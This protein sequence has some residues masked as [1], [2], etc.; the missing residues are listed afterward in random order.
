MT[1]YKLAFFGDFEKFACISV[2]CVSGLSLHIDS[3]D[4]MIESIDSMI[5]HQL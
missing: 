4:S 3:T 1:A 2:Y 5:L